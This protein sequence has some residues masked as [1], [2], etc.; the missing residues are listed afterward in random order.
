MTSS[1]TTRQRAI[2]RIRR[3]KRDPVTMVREEFHAEPDPW[4]AQLLRAFASTDRDTFRIA[5]KACKGPGKTTGLAWCIL[6]FLACYGEK[7]EHPKG[8]AT[9][10][11]KDN[12][13]DNLWPE[14]AKWMNR[15]EFFKAAFTWTNTRVF[16]KDHPET[17]FFSLRTWSKSADPQAQ[18]DTLAGLHAKF[19]L[20]VLDESGEIP[21][22]VMAT[23]EAGLANEHVGWAKILQ[24]GNPTSLEGPLYDACTRDRAMWT[25]IEITGD[26]DDPTRSPRISIDWARE[27]IRTYGADNPW[28]LVNVFGKFPPASLNTLIGPDEVHAAMRRYGHLKKSEFQHMQKR[29]GC[30]IARFG[31][32][33]SVIFPRQGLHA[34]K[35]IILRQAD[36]VAIAGRILL[37]IR[38]WNSELELIDDTGHWG[39]GV[40]DNLK[41]TGRSPLAIQ[42]HAPALDPRYKNRRAEMWL[43]MVDWIKH[44]GCLP[45]IPELVEELTIP[46]YT[47]SMG[48]FLLEDKD[49][50]KAR[51]GRSPDLADALAL[52]FAVPDQPSE[53]RLPPNFPQP[54]A[55]QLVSEWDPLA[56]DRIA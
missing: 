2:E 5:M 44:G 50:I 33:R 47:F 39:H 24:A 41:T 10:I 38:N 11:T 26:P 18:A 14:L 4:Q 55:G 45:F 53:L 29:L 28:V 27:Q 23:A 16:A 30:D 1:K 25:V 8:A 56:E 20:F 46:T 19:L 35:P 37:A 52:T 40:Y 7:G 31:D 43:T 48:Q 54:G 36:T 9:S 42:F 17:W 49:M 15:S 51:L 22:A 32:D 13:R 21:K 3:W 6:N 12:I 34:K